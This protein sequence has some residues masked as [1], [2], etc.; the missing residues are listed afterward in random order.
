MLKRL[1]VIYTNYK[2]KDMSNENRAEWA[3]H[4]TSARREVRKLIARAVFEATSIPEARVKFN[5]V[6]E[7]HKFFGVGLANYFTN[8]KP[9]VDEEHGRVVLDC[10]TTRYKKIKIKIEESLREGYSFDDIDP[11]VKAIILSATAEYYLGEED[12]NLLL[13]EWVKTTKSIIG[14]EKT[15]RFVNAVLSAIYNNIN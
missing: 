11:L 8:S 10:L 1:K 2:N 9:N 6:V 13:S 4:K 3:K 12:K 7:S 5:D 14:V 15:E